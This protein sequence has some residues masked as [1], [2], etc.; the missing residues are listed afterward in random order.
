MQHKHIPLKQQRD[1]GEMITTYFEFLKQNFKPFLNIFI[2]YN[3]IFILGFLGVSYLLV[4]GFVGTFVNTPVYGIGA[5]TSNYQVYF[6]AGAVGFLILFLITALL[7]YSLAAVY[8]IQYEQNK[9]ETVEK[10]KVWEMVKQNLGKIILFVIL[11]VFM[12]IA[13]MVVGV[14]ISF[15]PLLGSIAYYIMILAYMSWMGLSFMAMINDNKEVT[16]AF[17]EGW[18]LMKKFFWKSVLSNLV[19]GLL[20]GILMMVVLMIPGIL[21]GIYAF[22]SLDTGVDL[23]NSPMA[24]IVWTLAVSLLLI[25]YTI[26]QSLSQFVN[27]I[28]YYSL[29]EETYNE[30]TRERI[31]NIGAG[32]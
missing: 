13:L 4:T 23:A 11:A 12:Y 7:N 19:I 6:I 10:R 24:N 5:N 15:I 25:L 29:H 8:M 2:S 30:A 31:D 17:G 20:L 27:G 28:L 22:H 1:V 32:E 21:I 18:K 3:G 26:N 16:D 14:I 9:G